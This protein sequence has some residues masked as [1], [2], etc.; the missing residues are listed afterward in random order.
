MASAPKQPSSDFEPDELDFMEKLG[1]APLKFK[2]CPPPDLLR[3]ARAV[4][5]PEELKDAVQRH[6]R[7][8]RVCQILA[9]D[10]EQIQVPISSEESKRIR[11]RIFSE[12]PRPRPSR[13]RRWLWAVVPAAAV[14]AICLLIVWS[15]YP[16]KNSGRN[17]TSVISSATAAVFVLAPPKVSAPIP[18]VMRGASENREAYLSDLMRALAPYRTG[19]Y[20][21]AA[22]SLNALAQKYPTSPEVAFYSG[23]SLLMDGKNS[24]A[25]RTLQ[26]AETL[27]SG[28]L[29]GACQWYLAIAEVRSGHAEAAGSALQDLCNRPGEYQARA[30]AGLKE[31]SSSH[32]S[33]LPR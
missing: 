3:A 25:A 32:Q 30:C 29:G 15:R 17:N 33:T 13:S 1:G 26:R 9:A 16:A 22:K 24:D 18:L 23:V 12:A 11:D 19:N 14:V 27:A 2:G 4:A 7:G 20:A 6:L 28:P 21:E 8:C 10:L 31:L 5:V